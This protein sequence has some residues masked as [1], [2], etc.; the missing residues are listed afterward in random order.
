MAK[1]QLVVTVTGV[2]Q[3]SA[4]MRQMVMAIGN[5]GKEADKSAEKSSNFLT[6]L[7]RHM[8]SLTGMVQGLA[9]VYSLRR[10]AAA[11]DETGESLEQIGRVSVQTGAS[12]EDLSKW[13]FVAR[14]NNIDFELFAKGVMKA[15]ERLAEFSRAGSGP[16]REAVQRLNLSFRDG[17]GGI[18]SVS[19]LLPEILIQLGKVSS[20]EERIDL[21]GKIFGGSGEEFVTLVNRGADEI[22]RLIAKASALGVVYSPEQVDRARRYSLAVRD[23][24]DA[25]SGLKVRLFDAI[26]PAIAEWSEKLSRFMVIVPRMIGTF[27]ETLRT[28]FG[29]GPGAAEAYEGVASFMDDLGK[30]IWSGLKGVTRVAS[31]GTDTLL[32]VVLGQA[33]AQISLWFG[34]IPRKTT[35]WVQEAFA[36]SILGQFRS[37]LPGKLADEAGAAIEDSLNW[38]MQD[39]LELQREWVAGMRSA[40]KE[41]AKAWDTD[42]ISRFGT[43]IGDSRAELT[44][45]LEALGSSA[46]RVFGFSEAWAATA[47]NLEGV[48]RTMR[49]LRDLQSQ[50]VPIEHKTFMDGMVEAAARLK[51]EMGLVFQ[52][53]QQ[54]YLGITDAIVSGLSPAL[55]NAAGDVKNL[56]RYMQEFASNAFRQI[57]EITTRMLLFRAIAG[58]GNAVLSP[59]LLATPTGVTSANNFNLAV[60][61]AFANSGG[62]ITRFGLHRFAGGGFVPGPNVNRDVVPALLTPGEFV[63]NRSATARAGVGNL[64]RFNRGGPVGDA[65]GVN[66]TI[67]QS[68]V[69]PG[70][71]S[72]GATGEVDGKTMAA[73]KAATIDGVLEALM[74][75]PGYRERMRA[76]LA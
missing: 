71:G 73:F 54:Y 49:D 21:A 66:L 50:L 18:R 38:A 34:Q 51:D 29:R 12:I 17:A 1:K 39:R 68:I 6:R 41:A 25:W 22:E 13:R 64:A 40:S 59:S 28:A 45:L 76:A 5:M 75:S 33:D 46:D 57:S 74:R 7:A 27:A 37:R 24:G 20:Y 60:S 36:K 56:G 48:T 31:E 62:L 32:R 35:L 8:T 58:I 16:A 61:G 9:V 55:V 47:G 52:Q 15:Q 14:R 43:A 30:V 63:L 44:P 67:N 23:I 4:P 10:V 72:R 53:G 19:E 26:G 2:D 65:G 3:L 42:Y 11:I 70:S 69:L